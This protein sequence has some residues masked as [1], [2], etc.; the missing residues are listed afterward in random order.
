MILKATAFFNAFHKH[1][2]GLAA[3]K[4]KVIRSVLLL[5][6]FNFCQLLSVLYGSVNALCV[7]TKE[8][9]LTAQD[10]EYIEGASVTFYMWWTCTVHQILR[11]VFA[12]CGV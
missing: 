5:V 12:C 10:T 1:P 9:L 6:D 8:Q 7:T 11:H 3:A 2:E 4:T